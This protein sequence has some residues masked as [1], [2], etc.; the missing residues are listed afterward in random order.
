MTHRPYIPPGMKD[1]ASLPDHVGDMTTCEAPSCL[2]YMTGSREGYDLGFRNAARAA[3]D[4]LR[5]LGEHDV[6]DEIASTLE[7]KEEEPS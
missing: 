7:Y 4:R 3:V 1:N 6:A 5:F 2:I